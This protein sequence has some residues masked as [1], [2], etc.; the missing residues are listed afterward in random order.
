MN[1][2]K[3]KVLRRMAREEMAGDKGV[4]DRELKIARVRGADRIIN[5]PLSVRAMNLQLK[6]AYKNAQRTGVL[7]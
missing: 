7:A 6:K 4:V 5:E 1:Q 3:A 2:K